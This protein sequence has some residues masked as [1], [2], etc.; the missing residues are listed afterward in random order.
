MPNKCSV[1]GCSGRGGFS[2][3]SDPEQKIKWKA[4]IKISWDP[5][6]WST[7]CDSHFKPEDFKDSIRAQEPEP[8]KK[9]RRVLK[10]TAV[11]SIDPARDDTNIPASPRRARGPR[12]RPT[13]RLDKKGRS[14]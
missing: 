1:P 3:P 11:P 10:S 5:S 9:R 4:A 6:A 7:V 13:T 2:F 14:T 12:T 8:A